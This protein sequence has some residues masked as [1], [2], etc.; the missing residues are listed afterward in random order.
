M[1][2]FDEPK[3]NILIESFTNVDDL[4]NYSDSNT[5]SSI[6]KKNIELNSLQTFD[7]DNSNSG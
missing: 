5:S 2:I 4:I 1:S 6:S 7:F 3:E